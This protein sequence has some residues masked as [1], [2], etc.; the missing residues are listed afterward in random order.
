MCEINCQEII[1]N[2]EDVENKTWFKFAT[3]LFKHCGTTEAAVF[4]QEPWSCV[5]GDT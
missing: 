3:K 1:R 5:K 2:E 4:A